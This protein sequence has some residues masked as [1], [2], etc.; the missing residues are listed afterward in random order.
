MANLVPIAAATAASPADFS[1]LA[2]HKC[3]SCHKSVREYQIER[4]TRCK[5]VIYCGEECREKD[6]KT[7]KTVCKEPVDT[8]TP[9]TTDNEKIRRSFSEFEAR[10]L[11]GNIPK[12]TYEKYS[13]V[14]QTQQ[15][16]LEGSAHLKPDSSIVVVVGAQFYDDKFVEPLPQ[17]LEKCKKLIL[18]DVDPATLKV[19][20]TMLGTSE[21]VSTV[22]LDL[23]CALKDL[24]DFNHDFSQ[25]S[26]DVFSA[27][28]IDFLRKV[29]DD[30]EKREAGLPEVLAEGESADYVISSFVA[31]QLSLK[32]V[33]A[34]CSM[35]RKKFGVN[36]TSTMLPPLLQKGAAVVVEN[37][38]TQVT[39]HARD[40]CVWAG[41]KGRVYLAD[42]CW[43]DNDTEFMDQKT[44]NKLGQIFK[45]RKGFKQLTKKV[46]YWPGHEGTGCSVT[47]LLS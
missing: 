47:A 11:R 39:K 42:G 18:V 3:V 15:A 36:M 19:L 41:E 30:T 32:L 13:H 43:N 26:P 38:H 37:I 17:L 29:T 16:I 40:L 8:I 2:L 44:I 23:S 7:H 20:H 45:E 9:Y 14:L 21:K 4:C 25:S 10:F 5:E 34:L 46:W 33:D 35:F 6:R 22:V 31:T 27:G 1:A 12:V 24:R 28:V